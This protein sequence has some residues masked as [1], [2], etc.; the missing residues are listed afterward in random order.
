LLGGWSK[1][2]VKT[3]RLAKLGKCGQKVA[4][5]SQ[6]EKQRGATNL[7]QCGSK[8]EGGGNLG[9]RSVVNKW[10]GAGVRLGGPG[11]KSKKKKKQLVCGKEGSAKG[12]RKEP[13][14]GR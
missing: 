1:G 13:L 2:F 4:N 10:G 5:R 7:G 12:S 11:D 14:V 9:V 6:G 3:E 8:M